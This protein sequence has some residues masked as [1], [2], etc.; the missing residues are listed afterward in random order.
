[1]TGPVR[2]QTCSDG[3][4]PTTGLHPAHD[5]DA[6]RADL[7]AALQRRAP[8]YIP[9]DGR[10]PVAMCTGC[11]ARPARPGRR[12]CGWVCSARVAL[13]GRR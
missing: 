9:G 12:T 5:V 8:I 13:G 2:W 4:C 10:P 11:Y 1:M 3:R 6:L 7:T